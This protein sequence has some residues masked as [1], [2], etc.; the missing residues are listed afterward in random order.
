MK[1][2]KTIKK[3]YDIETFPLKYNITVGKFVLARKRLN[4][5]FEEYEKC[6]ICD[7]KLEEDSQPNYI[8]VK[9]VGNMF[10]CNECM[11]YL[12]HRE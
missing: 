5:S 8:S 7:K 3:E 1:I 4:I 9:G 2:T 6:F 10:A 12:T 11:D